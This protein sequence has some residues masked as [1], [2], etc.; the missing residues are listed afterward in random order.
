MRRGEDLPVD[1]AQ[2]RVD[3][4]H[5]ERQR[6]KDMRQHDAGEVE[7][8]LDAEGVEYRGEQSAAPESCG[9]REACD[10][11]RHGQWHVDKQAH[12]GCAAAQV[13]QPHGQPHT[14]CYRDDCCLCGCRER[15]DEHLA[16]LGTRG[17]LDEASP[18]HAQAQGDDGPYNIRHC[19]DTQHGED[20]RRRYWSAAQA[21]RGFE[22]SGVHV[23]SRWGYPGTN[24][25]G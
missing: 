18:R 3:G 8:E 15:D 20:D 5:N 23:N 25:P 16:G 22:V 2:C 13:V 17:N 10:D 11:R 19:R 6:D 24:Q 7:G 9:Q 1:L 12:D 14:E 4:D 21:K